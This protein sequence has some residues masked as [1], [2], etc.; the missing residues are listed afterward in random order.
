MEEEEVR[1]EV[2]FLCRRGA[3]KKT[4]EFVDVICERLRR[5]VERSSI[6]FFQSQW[7]C[8]VVVVKVGGAGEVTSSWSARSQFLCPTTKILKLRPLGSVINISL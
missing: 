8:R 7:D 2:A 3:T 6:F 4:E 1:K 5:N